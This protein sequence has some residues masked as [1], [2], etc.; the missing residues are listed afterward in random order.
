MNHRGLTH[1]WLGLALIAL[2]VAASEGD[3]DY[4]EHVMDA[5]GGHMQ[6]AADIARQKVAH[7]D[8]LKLHV[9]AIAELSTIAHTL[10]PAG[11]EG[12]DALPDIWENPE[13]FAGKISAFEEAAA[14]LKTAV[15]S[16]GDIGAAFQKLGQACK[17]CHDD[18]RED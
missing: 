13:D 11:S 6:A 7:T 14:G 1:L 18:Y 9:D 10:F 17:S 5:I 12:G 2:P 4:R 16:S 3:A 8:H 15:D